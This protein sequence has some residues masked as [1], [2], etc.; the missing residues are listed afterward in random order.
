M[1]RSKIMICLSSA[2]N[3]TGKFCDSHILFSLGLVYFTKYRLILECSNPYDASRTC[4]CLSSS[5]Y[6]IVILV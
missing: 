1:L 3:I 6:V 5:G 2:V 4:A